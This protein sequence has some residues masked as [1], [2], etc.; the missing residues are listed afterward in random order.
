MQRYNRH[1]LLGQVLKTLT[2][3]CWHLQDTLARSALKGLIWRLFS[4]GVS[5]AV[6]LVVFSDVEA[7]QA[8]AF[9]GAEAA[10]KFLMYFVFERLWLRLRKMPLPEWPP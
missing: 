1:L 7:G 3:A 5:I 2:S 6:A 4:T 8:L 9:G 10:L